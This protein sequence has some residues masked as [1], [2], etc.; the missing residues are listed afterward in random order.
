MATGLLILSGCSPDQST[1][2]LQQPASQ[3]Q[4]ASTMQPGDSPVHDLPTGTFT[5]TGPMAAAGLAGILVAGR[6]GCVYITGPTLQ[7]GDDDDYF[8]LVVWPSGFTAVGSFQEGVTIMDA[9]GREVARTGD[10]LNLGGGL[11]DGPH[12]GT[13]HCTD[14]PQ[15]STFMGRPGGHISASDLTSSAPTS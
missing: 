7:P 3:P 10:Y 2:D 14:H 9:D 8:T 1:S 4:P 5:T 13:E 6:D 11:G 12:P 15:S